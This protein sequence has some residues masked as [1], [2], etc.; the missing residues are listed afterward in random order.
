MVILSIWMFR[1]ESEIPFDMLILS[2]L[3]SAFR[4]FTIS[5][6]QAQYNAAP[7]Q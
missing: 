2:I 7:I 5:V 4:L 6:S 1:G 3:V